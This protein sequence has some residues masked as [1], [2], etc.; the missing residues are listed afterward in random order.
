MSNDTRPVLGILTGM[1]TE[2]AALGPWADDPRILVAMSA[3]NASRAREQAD[4]LARRD[5]KA[6]LSWGLA[7]GLNPALHAG[8]VIRPANVLHDGTSLPVALPGSGSI[9]AVERVIASVGD[10]RAVQTETGADAVD[11]ES[12]ALA[13]AAR[14]AGLPLYVVRVISDPAERA[15]PALAARAIGQDGK[16]RI[17]AVLGGLVSQP[18]A[19]IGLW[20]AWRDSGRALGTLR[21][22]RDAVIQGILDDVAKS[23]HADPDLPLRNV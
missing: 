18:S 4:S 12:G 21:A 16:P 2:V 15:L 8:D 9:A 11:M 23:G 7:G 10:K 22:Q 17:G 14:H 20:H 1:A 5:V 6:M 3:A 19:A 13:R